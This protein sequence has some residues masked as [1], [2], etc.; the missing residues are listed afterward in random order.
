MKHRAIRHTERATTA[1]LAYYLDGVVVRYIYSQGER[2]LAG[3]SWPMMA[4]SHQANDLHDVRH[5]R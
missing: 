2:Q 5:R 4:L 3:I 1:V